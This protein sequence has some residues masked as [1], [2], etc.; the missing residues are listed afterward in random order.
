VPRVVH[1][2]IPADDPERC[3]TFYRGVF[4]WTIVKWDGPMPYWP[5]TT[6]TE[7]PGINGA[8]APRDMVHTVTNTIDVPDIAAYIE[9]VRTSGGS[10]LTEPMEIPGV[11]RFAYCLDTE[12]NRFGMMQFTSG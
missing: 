8:V 3:N 4:G 2:E 10:V 11:G 6:G 7:G 5:A 1:F 12:G 9:K